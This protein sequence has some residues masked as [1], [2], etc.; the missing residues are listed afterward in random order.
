MVTKYADRMVHSGKT[1]EFVKARKG[2]KC[3]DC[4]M[5]INPGEFYYQVTYNGSG[6]ASIKFPDRLH[7]YCIRGYFKLT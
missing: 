2:F 5:P 6:L 1:A 7:C 4:G 3:D